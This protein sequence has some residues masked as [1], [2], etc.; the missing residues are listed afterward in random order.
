M[1][2]SRPEN[3]VLELCHS[4]TAHITVLFYRRICCTS[5]TKRTHHKCSGE[6]VLS[7]LKHSD[8]LA[9]FVSGWMS[10]IMCNVVYPTVRQSDSFR[11]YL[12]VTDSAFRQ[13]DR[14]PTVP[15]RGGASSQARQA[16]HVRQSFRQS[17]PTV[18]R[19]SPDSP[20]SPPTVPTVPT[21]RAQSTKWWTRIRESNR[22]R[23]SV[24]GSRW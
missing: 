6:A 24:H 1:K 22:R 16:R 11:Q 20:D 12:T 7:I 2:V 23:R 5:I 17:P 8:H 15:D 21:A 19:Q 13:S 4:P 18:P 10:V 14:C 3:D 9:N